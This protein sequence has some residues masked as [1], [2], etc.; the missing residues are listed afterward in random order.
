MFDKLV[1]PVSVLMLAFAGCD[2]IFDACADPRAITHLGHT[3][4][5]GDFDAISL[6]SG[7]YCMCEMQ[8][9]TYPTASITSTLWTIVMVIKLVLL[10]RLRST[11]ADQF[12]LFVDVLTT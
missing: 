12:Q 3:N 2:E 7:C 6:Y 1:V 9:T 8:S 10:A 11:I 5:G 4:N